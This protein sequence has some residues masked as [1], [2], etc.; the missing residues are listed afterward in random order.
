MR[1]F[2]Q[3]LLPAV[4]GLVAL[5]FVLAPYGELELIIAAAS[6]WA[7]NFNGSP[8]SPLPFS[9]ADW[10]ITIH[11]RDPQT[12]QQLEAMQAQHGSDCSAPPASHSVSAYQDAVFI[13]NNHLMTA[14]NAGG[15]GVIYL[16][17]DQMVDFSQGEAIVKFDMSTL[18]T[19]ARDWVDLWVTPFDDNL[20]LP[21][22]PVYPDLTGYPSRSVHLKMDN[23]NGNGTDFTAETIRNFQSN[24]IN[25][26]WWTGYE[27][28][29]QPSA[30]RRDTFELHLSRT[31]LKF[32]MPQYNFW[33]IDA[34]MADLGWTQGILQIGHHSY[35]PN[36]ACDYDGSCGPNTWHWNNISINSGVPF[37]I[38]HGDRRFV[39][40][41]TSPTIT[42]GAPAPSNAH[43]RFAAVGSNVQVS[44]NN[45]QSW[46]TARLQPAGSP[47]SGRAQSYW[48]SVPAG[49]SSVQ[50]R[51]QN[52]PY[53]PW[54]IRDISIW[55]PGQSQIPPPTSTS[56]P[57]AHTSTP[58]PTPTTSVPTPT[59]TS[60]SAKTATPTPT[61]PSVPGTR[62]VTFDDLSDTD[63]PLN[64][65][66]PDGLIDW[67]TNAWFL[68]GPYGKISGN[69][70]S[71]NGSSS[72]SARFQFVTPHLLISVRAYNGDT[73]PSNVTL[74]CPG[75]PLKQ[76]MLAPQQVATIQ[77]NW[78]GTCTSV[79]V[80][81]SNGW[82][83]NFTDFLIK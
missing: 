15:Y 62:R 1:Q 49:I 6:A 51:A 37:T 27:S 19:S 11:S 13:C 44:F 81:T 70:V 34:N 18:R 23:A 55:A 68:S 67:G 21:L 45:G 16:T 83:T 80:S 10:D 54:D 52:T 43:L 69:S 47:D 61:P 41:S 32:G 3:L 56:T 12:W 2:R 8:P 79:R 25:G 60:I 59:S 5:I 46:Q 66:Y 77:T 39:N 65:E 38:L 48:T 72:R 26:N 35:T 50:L 78:A 63:Q 73:V 29:L 58:T 31:H 71:F 75:K 14:I 17:P 9:S 36:K 74:S 57:T 40:A 33:W 4:I 24:S 53:L 76:V 22:E 82:A 42:F 7:S 20:Q 28:F 64:G 30:T